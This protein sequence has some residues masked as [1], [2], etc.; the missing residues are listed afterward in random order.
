MELLFPLDDLI[1][2]DGLDAFIFIHL[3]GSILFLTSGD[4]WSNVLCFRLHLVHVGEVHFSALLQTGFPS[5]K[6]IYAILTTFKDYFEIIP[7]Q[8]WQENNNWLPPQHLL[9]L[10]TS[11]AAAV[12]VL[13]ILGFLDRAAFKPKTSE[14]RCW[15]F[16]L[17]RFELAEL[18][19]CIKIE[20]QGSKR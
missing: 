16:F 3:S 11:D 7:L 19:I 4:K 15:R 20:L 12:N 9:L 14:L 8:V 6:A 13:L 10:S 18:G 5:W 2:F 17:P 1:S